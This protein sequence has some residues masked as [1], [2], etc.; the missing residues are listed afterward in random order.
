MTSYICESGTCAK[1]KRVSLIRGKL[2]RY[3]IRHGVTHGSPREGQHNR[4]ELAVL[5]DVGV[6]GLVVDLRSMNVKEA[7]QIEDAIEGLPPRKTRRDQAD[8][9]L[10]RVS[11]RAASHQSDDDDDDGEEEEYE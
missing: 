6:Q 5:Q 9:L 8:A 11:Q 2:S 4:D 7:I 10:P 3:C 1:V